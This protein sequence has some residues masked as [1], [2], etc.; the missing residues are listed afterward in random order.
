MRYWGKKNTGEIG[1][2]TGADDIIG[3]HPCQGFI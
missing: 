2:V 1:T 3:K